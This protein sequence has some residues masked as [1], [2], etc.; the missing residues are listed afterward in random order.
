MSVLTTGWA[1]AKDEG[2]LQVR[3]ASVKDNLVFLRGCSKGDVTHIKHLQGKRGS[4]LVQN[5]LP[6]IPTHMPP[7]GCHISLEITFW[8]LYSSLTLVTEVPAFDIFFLCYMVCRILN[9]WPGGEVLPPAL[10]VQRH[11]HWNPRTTRH[12]GKSWCL[13]LRSSV[14]SSNPILAPPYPGGPSWSISATPSKLRPHPINTTQVTLSFDIYLLIY[15]SLRP[16]GA[17]LKTK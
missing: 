14:L 5:W 2:H 16:A 3:W 6:S 9:L 10:E 12:P 11:N 1:G 4:R 13:H 8:P 15:L 7:S 17:F